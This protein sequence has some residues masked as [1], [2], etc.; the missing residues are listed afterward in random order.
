MPTC[1]FSMLHMAKA[2]RT[3]LFGLSALLLLAAGII[4]AQYL[5]GATHH[6][7]AMPKTGYYHGYVDA[8][9]DSM[10]GD[11][12]DGRDAIFD[13]HFEGETESRF[14][15]TSSN[16]RYTNLKL[17]WSGNLSE[18]TATV[19]LPSFTFHSNTSTGIL[20]QPLLLAWL[21]GAPEVASSNDVARVDR[22]F[23]YIE[24]AGQGTLPPPRHHLYYTKG[25]PLNVLIAH[26]RLG[27]DVG[28]FVY[29]WIAVW[30]AMV[31]G[32]GRMLWRKRSRAELGS[33]ASQNQSSRSGPGE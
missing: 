28:D 16:F 26:W 8:R 13:V 22:V 20:T 4:A 14:R 29:V 9:I 5:W 12:L 30:V 3:I 24:A 19:S 31:I 18:G 10:C 7:Y 27:Y 25:P 17:E 11:F 32:L 21:V 2:V 6:R 23:R 1:R 15:W 33:P